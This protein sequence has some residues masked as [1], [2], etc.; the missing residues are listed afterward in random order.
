MI[1]SSSGF[2]QISSP[3]LLKRLPKAKA[4]REIGGLFVFAAEVVSSDSTNL[5]RR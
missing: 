2:C 3:S 4:R 5:A 1:Q